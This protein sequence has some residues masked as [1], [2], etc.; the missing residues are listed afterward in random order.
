MPAMNSSTGTGLRE[1]AAQRTRR[2]REGGSFSSMLLTFSLLLLVLALGFVFG[3]VVV[4]RAYVKATGTIQKAPEATAPG[5]QASAPASPDT[6]GGDTSATDEGATASDSADTQSGQS[7]LTTGDQTD[8]S[9]TTVE[10][11]APDQG[12]APGGVR[13]AVQVGAFG[14][15]DSARQAETELTNAGYPARIVRERR[16][17]GSTYKVLTGAYRTK[18]RAQK[19]LTEL[20]REGFS[21]AFVVEERE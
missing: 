20:T 5:G 17:T 4:A 7:D 2:W 12:A 16:G 8:A 13:Y 9:D 6:S 11:G 19:A 14:S 15:E 3:R 1:P 21:E 10:G 18:D